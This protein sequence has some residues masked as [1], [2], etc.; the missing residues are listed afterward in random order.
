MSEKKNCR[1]FLEYLS[2]YLDGTLDDR[3]I[4]DDIENHLKDC[5]NCQVV[6][7]TLE[8]TISLYHSSAL[9]I[10]L[11]AGVRDRLYERLDLENYRI[12]PSRQD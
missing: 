7:N 8:K 2:D 6:Y 4:C 3:A 12:D 11:P 10:T 1:A 5:H 9:N